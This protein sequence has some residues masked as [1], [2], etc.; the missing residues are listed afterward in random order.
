[1]FNV[2][3]KPLMQGSMDRKDLFSSIETNVDTK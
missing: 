2:L 3:E 1:M